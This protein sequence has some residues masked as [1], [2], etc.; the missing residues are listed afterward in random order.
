LGAVV[1]NARDAAEVFVAHDDRR[2][3]F[4]DVKRLVIES[5]NLSK[6]ASRI[7]H[8]NRRAI[9][10]QKR[11]ELLADLTRS[12]RARCICG[13]RGRWR[14]SRKS[15][16]PRIWTVTLRRLFVTLSLRWRIQ[17]DGDHGRFADQHD[18]SAHVLFLPI[19]ECR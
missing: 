2:H 12:Q 15:E 3:D 4:V 6:L 17:V 14:R 7:V 18:L 5:A 19:K 9:A 1:E 8:P 13:R 16:W 10:F 11:V